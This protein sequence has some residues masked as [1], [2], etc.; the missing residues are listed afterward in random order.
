MSTFRA[1]IAT[2]LLTGIGAA[3]EKV[4]F[5]TRD[6]GLIHADQH[7][8]GERGV[9]LAHRGRFNKDSRRETE[10]HPTAAEDSSALRENS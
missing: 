3:P 1:F 2:L 7:G 8:R 4:S 5:T 6:G 9:V 10:R